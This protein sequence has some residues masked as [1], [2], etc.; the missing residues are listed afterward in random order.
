ML[1]TIIYIYFAVVIFVPNLFCRGYF[2]SKFILRFF[3]VPNLFCEGFYVPNLFCEGFYVP[4]LF[5][6]GFG[7]IGKRY[8][9]M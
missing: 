6:E 5:C 7:E 2:R 9:S 8:K 3:Y 4:N 1:P